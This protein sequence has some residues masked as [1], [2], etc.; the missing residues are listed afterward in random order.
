MTRLGNPV[1]VEHPFDSA[2]APSATLSIGR[3][4]PRGNHGSEW[5]QGR[6]QVWPCQWKEGGEGAVTQRSQATNCSLQGPSCSTF[7]LE[8][9]RKGTTHDY[10]LFLY[11]QYHGNSAQGCARGVERKVHPPLVVAGSYSQ[12]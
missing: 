2:D 1:A 3:P 10:S 11:V 4:M 9:L 8:S 7:A 5:S 6:A 12:L